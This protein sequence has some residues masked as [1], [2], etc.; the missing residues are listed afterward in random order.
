MILNLVMFATFLGASFVLGQ[1]ATF[2]SARQR[3]LI[4]VKVQNRRR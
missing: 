2:M 3:E 4:R 1:A